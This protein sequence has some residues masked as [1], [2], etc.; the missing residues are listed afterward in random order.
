MLPNVSDSVTM[1][2]PDEVV[3][4]TM[5]AIFGSSVIVQV[6]AIATVVWILLCFYYREAFTYWKKRG[7]PY[8]EPKIPFGN[9]GR[10]LSPN[11][12]PVLMF[13][14]F[15][16]EFEGE[17][18]G[19]IF[20]FTTPTLIVRDPEIIKTVLVRDFESFYSTGM[21]TTVKVEPLTGHLGFLSGPKWKSLRIKLTPT[22]TSGK[23]KMMFSTIVET[24]KEL[25]K[26]LGVPADN[27]EE[28]DVKEI[29][30]R[31]STDVIASCAFGIEC[32]CLKV[33]NAEFRSWG[34][35][36]FETTFSTRIAR[37]ITFVAPFLLDYV[38]LSMIPKDVSIYF[39]K[40]VRDTIEYREKNNIH[41]N[42]FMQ[43]MIQLKNKTLG[44]AEEDAPLK[45]PDMVS[46]DLKSKEPFGEYSFQYL[47]SLSSSSSSGKRVF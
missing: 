37:L 10:I 11:K 1:P 43:L 32:N 42:D 36:V 3:Q 8:L 12:N 25:Q 45:V 6:V 18:Y 30:A 29:L 5:E 47:S 34:K 2:T 44:V 17:R 7:V 16:K 31:F 4:P 20:K 26:Y 39:R 38:R 28:I 40:M 33:P 13:D 23:M 9:Y 24:G 14:D 19:G 21:K 41:R 35:K 46:S 15:Y 22:F 27:N